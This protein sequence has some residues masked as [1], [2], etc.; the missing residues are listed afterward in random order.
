MDSNR[1][2]GASPTA[3]LT[4][5]TLIQCDRCRS[6]RTEVVMARNRHVAGREG[7][8]VAVPRLPRGVAIRGRTAEGV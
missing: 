1:P 8:G 2:N 3:A 7:F 5:P 6:A 4:S